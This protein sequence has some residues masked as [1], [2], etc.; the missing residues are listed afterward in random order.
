MR[1]VAIIQA[2]VSSVR[3]P[4]KVLLNLNGKSVLHNVVSRV[5][6]ISGLDEIVVATSDRIDDDI[7]EMETKRIG[8]PLYRGSLEDVLSRYY[9]AARQFKADIIMR[10]TSDCPLIAPEVSSEILQEF[11][12]SSN[13][14]YVSNTLKRTYPR[15][16][17]T[18][19]FH[20]QAL[21]K[22]Y[23][24]S[25][26]SSERE[27]VTPYLYNNRKDFTIFDFVD[28]KNNYSQF[29][30]TLDTL[31]DYHLIKTIYY[32]KG[33]ELNYIDLVNLFLRNHQWH[34]INNH[35]E[36]KVY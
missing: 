10:I 24:E 2:R 15:G 14:D 31:E 6:K 30:W 12:N 26:L 28:N 36:Q 22:A 4:C 35:I 13:Y 23:I 11:V 7:I 5:Q 3:L 16:L 32:N 17:D 29:R 20:F 9:N 33:D 18:E 8:I 25:K 27:H 1:K 21:E 19:V 34:L